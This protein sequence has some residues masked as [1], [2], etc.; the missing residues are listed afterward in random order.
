M[1]I[2]VAGLIINRLLK[3]IPIPDVPFYLLFS[4][5]MGPVLGLVSPPRDSAAALNGLSLAAGVIL[6]QGGANIPFPDLR[7]LWVSISALA[8]LGVAVASLIM[9]LAIH[10]IWA[11]PWAL[12]AM[13]AVVIANTDPATVIPVFSRIAIEPKIRI[14]MEA[15]SAF[16]DTMSAVITSFLLAS[17]LPTAHIAGTLALSVGQ[18]LLG[19]AVGWSLG[20]FAGA[21]RQRLHRLSFL[22]D[23]TAP[24]VPYLL[25]LASGGNGYIAAFSAG[26]AWRFRQRQPVHPMMVDRVAT[27]ARVGIFTW[28]GLAVPLSPL[29]A[30]W[31]LALG[32]T[33]ILMFVARPLTVLASVGW[34]KEWRPKERLLMM[35][36]RETGAI[37]AVLAIQVGTQFPHWRSLIMA[38]V[39]AT[40]VITVAAQAPTTGLF[41]RILRLANAQKEKIW[42]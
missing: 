2:M 7:R 27:L 25:A 34:I 1:G 29:R 15:E 16:N 32:S 26:L 21:L 11:L 19:L 23:I 24:V 33:L 35:W 38:V 12:T 41:A 3:K 4:I 37:S 36:V 10:F 42:G 13:I 22:A 20:Y 39:F 18:I 5:L 30:H 14:T 17:L 9:A 28:L 6:F 31:P 40:I 8:T